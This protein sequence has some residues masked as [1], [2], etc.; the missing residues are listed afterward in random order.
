MVLAIPEE[1]ASFFKRRITQR[2]FDT[3]QLKVLVV[4][5]EREVIVEWLPQPLV[6]N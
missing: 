2:L 6:A 4:D 3:D 5:I 1:A